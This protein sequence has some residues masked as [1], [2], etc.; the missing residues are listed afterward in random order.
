MIN[1]RIV[2]ASILFDDKFFSGTITYQ[3]APA[4]NIVFVTNSSV[5]LLIG[6]DGN[7]YVINGNSIINACVAVKLELGDTQTL[8]HQENGVWVLNEVP[9]YQQELAKCQR[10]Q[11][12][13]GR[14]DYVPIG[15]GLARA[16]DFV[17][18]TLPT[19]VTLRAKPS[20]TIVGGSIQLRHEN[21]AIIQ[22][23]SLYAEMFEQNLVILAVNVSNATVGGAYEAYLVAGTK[24]ILDA[25]L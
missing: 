11:V 12:V 25:N 4:Q 5:S 15:I 13:F 16:S 8:A 17:S 19:P 23:S 22:S 20:A 6:V 14:D 24:V 18:I 9:N 2:T 7:F 1:G 10:H 3:K 21:T